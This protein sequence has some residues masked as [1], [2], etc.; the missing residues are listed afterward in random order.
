MRRVHFALKINVNFTHQTCTAYFFP[1]AHIWDHF[2]WLPLSLTQTLFLSL[3]LTHTFAFCFTLLLKST[4]SGRRK[5]FLNT[6]EISYFHE[7]PVEEKKNQVKKY[8]QNVF[9]FLFWK[10]R[11]TTVF[12][13]E[14]ILPHSSPN[15]GNPFG[16]RIFIGIH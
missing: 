13:C 9:F 7:Q 5:K 11:C 10:M 16:I 15:H 14:L 3:T 2:C 8:K 6:K 4:F 1:V 12:L